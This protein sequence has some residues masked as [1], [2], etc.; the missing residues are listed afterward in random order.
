MPGQ[1]SAECPDVLMKKITTCL[2]QTAQSVAQLKISHF[3]HMTLLKI[4]QL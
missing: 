4:A 2:P 1:L 3:K